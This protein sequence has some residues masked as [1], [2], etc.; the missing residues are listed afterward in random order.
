MLI[1]LDDARLY[2]RTADGPMGDLDTYYQ[3]G[4]VFT[5]KLEVAGGQIQV[6][7]NGELKAEFVRDWETCYFKAG[8]YL[9]SNPQRWGDS[10]QS[11]GQ[12]TIYNLDVSHS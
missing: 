2:V 1:R 6:Y 11:Y 5:L 3:L 10:G 9:Q 4:S 7:Y 8:V 12:V